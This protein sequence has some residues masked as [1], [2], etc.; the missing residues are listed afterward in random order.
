[1]SILLNYTLYEK[2]ISHV[3]VVGITS[4][5]V[6]PAEAIGTTTIA[7]ASSTIMVVVFR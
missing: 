7:I 2:F 3:V 1:M 6:T 5:T 4:N